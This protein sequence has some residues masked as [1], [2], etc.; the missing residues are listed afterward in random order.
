M[1]RR[2]F[3]KSGLVASSAAFMPQFLNGASANLQSANGNKLVVIQLAGGNDGLNTLVPYQN[4]IYYKSRP[5]I[6]I[7]KNQVLKLNH[8]L[9]FNPSLK[10]M[11]QFFENGEMSVYNQVGYPNQNKSHFRATDIWLT[12][13]DANQYLSTGWLGKYLDSD[14]QKPHHAIEIG[15]S[16]SL[17]LKGDKGYGMA[18][19]HPYTLM[20]AGNTDFFKQLRNLSATDSKSEYLYKTFVQTQQSTDYIFDK[21]RTYKSTITYPNSANGRSLKT[22]AQLIGAGVDTSIYYHSIGGFDTHGAQLG[23]QKQLHQN[24][25][26]ALSAFVND[27]KQSNNW[28]STRILIFSEFGRRIKENGSKGTDHGKASNVYVLG[29]GIDTPGFQNGSTDLTKSENND[30]LH[31]I[32][33]RSIYAHLLKNWLN[34]EVGLPSS[35]FTT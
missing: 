12:A 2:T 27:L 3:L 20:R 35:G 19:D 25:D 24:L 10:S 23:R 33:F 7:P 34:S 17:A 14:C 4:D 13:S 26:T 32:D 11:A 1:K 6:A 31:T 16:L 22:I 9:G 15:T 30:L 28:N 21:F 8:D 5:N 29:G 18:F